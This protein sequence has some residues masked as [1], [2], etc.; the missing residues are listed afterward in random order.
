[1][2]GIMTLFLAILVPVLIMTSVATAGE[3]YFKEMS[4]KI[5][6]IDATAGAYSNYYLGPFEISSCYDVVDLA[7]TPEVDSL[8]ANPIWWGSV[9]YK[10]GD[11][12]SYNIR[13]LA[14][15]YGSPPSAYS[16]DWSD[17]VGTAT[18]TVVL[19]GDTVETMTKRNTWFYDQ[20][21]VGGDYMLPYVWIELDPDTLAGD[22]LVDNLIFYGKIIC[23]GAVR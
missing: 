9:T 6:R 11:T 22:T 21:S 2:K 8:L 18:K 23:S 19:L 10:S 4:D 13:A 5:G 3:P 17:S 1:M 20:G 12:M 14:T 7:E 15:I 16:F